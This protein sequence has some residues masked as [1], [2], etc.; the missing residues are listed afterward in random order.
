MVLAENS[1]AII[2]ENFENLNDW[3]PLCFYKTRKETTY[4]ATV[5]NGI[6]CL[7]AQS[8]RSAS[9]LLCNKEFDVYQ[10]PIV[11][12]R[13]KVSNVYKKGDIRKK[14]RSDSPARLFIMFKY[15]PQKAGFFTRVKYL[16]A[17]QI[18][19]RYPPESALCYIWANKPHKNRIIPSPSFEQL[20]YIVLEAGEEQIG[21]WRDE[22]INI[23]NDY[24]KAFGKVPPETAGISF[25]NNSDNT[26]E[27]STSWLSSLEVIQKPPSYVSDYSK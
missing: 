4:E 21:R 7:K 6:T 23:V 22:E 13:W 8:D 26:A 19:G 3:K 2:Q 10:Y 17:K 27:S 1:T 16:L 18:Y 9:A 15:D 24:K 5:D 11:K 25:M 12:W 14:E 20:R